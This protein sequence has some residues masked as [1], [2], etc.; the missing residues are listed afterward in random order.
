[1]PVEMEV[2]RWKKF[3]KDLRHCACGAKRRTAEHTIEH[4]AIFDSERRKTRIRLKQFGKKAG[5]PMK[6]W[7]NPIEKRRA[8]ITEVKRFIGHIAAIKADKKDGSIGP[9]RPGDPRT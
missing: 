6:S 9:P 8:V 2:G 1:M 3:P 4:C 5:G 7:P